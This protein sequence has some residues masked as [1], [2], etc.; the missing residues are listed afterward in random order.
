MLQIKTNMV[1]RLWLD[2]RNGHTIYLVFLMTFANFITIQYALLV[3]R[4]PSLS[5]VFSNLWLFAAMFV[6]AYVPISVV[7]GYW[8]R[9][10]QMKVEQEAFFN[11][12][13]V[14]ARVWL[15][16][17]ELIEGNLTEDE[18]KVMRNMLK[19]IIVK[20]NAKNERA[21]AADAE[22]VGHDKT[23]GQL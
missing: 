13:V 23:A 4:V 11:E 10:S 15:F 12:N 8:H 14:Q 2:F 21:P 5:S 9:K 22:L 16:M 1:R 20:D 18:K 17:F 19:Q 6:A 3:D 7:V